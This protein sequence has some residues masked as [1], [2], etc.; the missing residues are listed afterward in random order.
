MKIQI[1]CGVFETNSS[2]VHSLTMCASDEFQKWKNGEK[3][4]YGNEN[5]FDTK[6]NIIKYLKTKPSYTGEFCYIG[7]DWYDTEK[8]NDIFDE[9]GIKTYD[10]F[11]DDNWFETYWQKYTSKSGD[12]IVAFGYYGHD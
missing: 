8:V 4:F 10:Q 12:E 5:R 1:R 9:E 11:F 7:V 3:L 6:E 2:S